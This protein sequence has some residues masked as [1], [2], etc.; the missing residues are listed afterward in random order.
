[1][2][3]FTMSASCRCPAEEVW[4]LLYD[5]FRFS[6]WWCGTAR[7]EDVTDDTAV[8][9]MAEWPDFPYPTRV[10]T[11]SDGARVVISCLLSDIVQE[12]SL[13][14]ADEG[15]TI[16]LRVEVPAAEAGRL[17]A[18]RGELEASMPLLVAAAERAEASPGTPP[19]VA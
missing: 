5:P 7:V 18:V 16:R 12:W 2:P 10:T 13:E 19:G 17:A 14:P 11:R 15:C 8:R 4:K 9:Y 1:M 3:E 6:E